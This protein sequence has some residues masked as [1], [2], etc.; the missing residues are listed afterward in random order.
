[1][2]PRVANGNETSGN[3]G[4]GPRPGGQAGWPRWPKP[5]QSKGLGA[6][7]QR[8]FSAPLAGRAVIGRALTLHQAPNGRPAAAA[9]LASAVVDAQLLAVGPRLVPE[10]A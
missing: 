9:G 3:R 1:G 10:R 6:R 4:T 8:S 5:K 2:K 7:R